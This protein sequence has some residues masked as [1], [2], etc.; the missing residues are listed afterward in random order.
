MAKHTCFTV[1]GEPFFSI[2]GQLHN[3]SGYALGG[4]DN[5]VKEA[6][7]EYSFRSLQAIGANTAAIPLCWD[8]FE[9]QEGNFD[10]AYL[11]RI[12]DRVREH[13]LHAVLLWF[14]TWKNGQMEYTPAWVKDDP[15][16]FPRA[17]CRDGT[18]TSVL[19]AHSEANRR[20]DC[21][22]FCRL[23]EE[24]K[25]YDGETGTVI[26]VQ[27]ENEP[28]M[29]APTRRD[30]GPDGEAAFHSQVPEAV[31]QAVKAEGEGYLYRAWTEKGCPESGDWRE[32]FGRYGAEACTAYGVASYIDSLA[33]AGKEIYDIFMY[34]NVWTDRSGEHGWSMG[35][36]EYPCGGAVSKMLPLWHAV[37]VH[38]DAICPDVYEP[39]PALICRN[40]DIY[41]KPEAGWPLYI[42]ESGLSY[43]NATWMFRAIGE[44][45]G[46]GYH[47]FGVESWLD[48]EGKLAE[49]AHAI[50]RSFGILQAVSPLILKAGEG[51][52]MYSF[53]QNVGEDSLYQELPGWKCRVS[54]TGA[55][56]DYA[57]WVPMD[58]HHRKDIPGVN[59]I[60][61]SLEEE[62]G[63][64]LLFQMGENEFYLAGH[65]IRLF[66][67]PYEPEDGSIPAN[68]L[69][70]QHQAHS[71]EFLTL[72]EGHF[73]N[74][75]FVADRI[76][77][78]DE[79]RHG[80][81]AQADCGVVHFRIRKFG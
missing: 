33:A 47:V 44:K 50:R 35:G 28:G 7:M 79:S 61:T 69:N 41:A 2:G 26:A 56:T 4:A 5:P 18:P 65:K 37:G 25:A 38:L 73:E 1:K 66:F 21:L 20:Q 70:G 72:E 59:R 3:S 36:L 81:W 68:C 27:V 49:T 77:S 24:L 53:C 74:G 71:M 10:V 19:S 8:A 6:D 75:V 80:V 11:H 30:F 48:E 16:R 52:R 78:G 76:R 13:D 51:C 14:A 34:V 43:S 9:P 54:F 39:A 64:G 32:V 55:G 62:T 42:P 40:Q 22:A 45:K 17:M 12:I 29:Y 15:E 63:R 31:L 46:I 67:M 58:Y 57:G 23:M 60:P